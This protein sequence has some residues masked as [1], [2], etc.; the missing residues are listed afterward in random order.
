MVQTEWILSQLQHLSLE[1]EWYV[2]MALG[3]KKLSRKHISIVVMK[4]T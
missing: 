1:S 2:D 4:L 3:Y